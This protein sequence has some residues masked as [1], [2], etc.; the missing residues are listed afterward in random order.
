L[1]VTLYSDLESNVSSS[2]TQKRHVTTSG[3]YDD[4]IAG[5]V[6]PEITLGA[7]K[8]IVVPSTY[9]PGCEAGFKLIVYSTVSGVT[10]TPI[11]NI[12]G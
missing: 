2:S 6:T 12:V 5:V 8:Y 9:T 1:N 11:D 4:G 10:L 7:G 3:A